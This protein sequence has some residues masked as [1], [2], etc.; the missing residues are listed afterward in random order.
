MGPVFSD[1][2]L[3]IPML[4]IFLLEES[5]D[6]F[7]TAPM[8][9][10]RKDREP[11]QFEHE[12]GENGGRNGQDGGEG[13]WG[14]EHSGGRH[15]EGQLTEDSEFFQVEGIELL[16]YCQSESQSIGFAAEGGN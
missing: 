2:Q 4:G 7:P 5:V 16:Q 14:A 9:P 12:L 1:D 6:L 11:I 13:E 3:E 10:R 8:L 15:A